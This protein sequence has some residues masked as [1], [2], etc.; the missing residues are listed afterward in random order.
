MEM[1]LFDESQKYEYTG[2]EL[3]PKV[4][5]EILIEIFDGKRFTRSEA[6][7]ECKKFHTEHGG[8]LQNTDYT[9]AFKKAAS[10]LKKDGIKNVV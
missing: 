6:I 10:D 9:G 3:T 4:M 2:L 7:D 1:S 8:I 5:A